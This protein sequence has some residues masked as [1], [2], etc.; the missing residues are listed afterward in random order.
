MIPSDALQVRN[1][2]SKSLHSVSSIPLLPYLL[3]PCKVDTWKIAWKIN[4]SDSLMLNEDPMR[5]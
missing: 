2:T 4:H 1:A 3:T 5:A